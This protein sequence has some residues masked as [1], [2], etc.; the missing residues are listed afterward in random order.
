MIMNT[1]VLFAPVINEGPDGCVGEIREFEILVGMPTRDLAIHALRIL[2]RDHCRTLLA[3]DETSRASKSQMERAVLVV[4][5]GFEF[6]LDQ[7]L[8][9][10]ATI[11]TGLDDRATSILLIPD[12]SAWPSVFCEKFPRAFQDGTAHITLEDDKVVFQ[13]QVA[14]MPTRFDMKVPR[15]ELEGLRTGLL[16]AGRTLLVERVDCHG[17]PHSMGSPGF[18]V[19][20]KE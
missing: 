10:E 1:K 18:R 20:A 13:T 9:I 6:H 8:R 3:R 7:M 11:V 2:L 5:H 15:R 17:D 14:Q 16:A 19:T 12:G 4:A